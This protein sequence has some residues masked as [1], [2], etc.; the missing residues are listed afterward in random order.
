MEELTKEIAMKQKLFFLSIILLL[1]CASGMQAE[2]KKINSSLNGNL[3]TYYDGSEP[4]KAYILND[5]V[6]EIGTGAS[7]MKS[8]DKSAQTKL[9]KGNIKL[10]KVSDPNLKAELSK[11][12]VPKSN[13]NSLFV[14][15]LSTTG[16]E[17]GLIVPIGGV[18][19]ELAKGT[20]EASAK[21][22]ASK[23]KL[24]L[25]KKVVGSFYLVE[26]PAGIAAIE[27]ANSL[28]E[29]QGVVSATPNFW[30]NAQTK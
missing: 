12:N 16:D 25:V 2:E 19:V 29:K 15:A 8:L 6:V 1:S 30:K 21:A 17:S 7:N 24:N 20:D 23:N 14:P 4:R 10:H 3:L 26:S 13:S 22:W 11:G 28:R 18:I 9:E 27:L 5:Y